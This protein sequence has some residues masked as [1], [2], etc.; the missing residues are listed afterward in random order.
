[1]KKIFLIGL[2]LLTVSSFA[3]EV[4][5]NYCECN[6]EEVVKKASAYCQYANRTH[7]CSIIAV[8]EVEDT[9]NECSK[10]S[11]ACEDVKRYEVVF[12]GK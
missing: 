5:G 7:P 8:E 4:V 2:S 9:Y 10:V 12:A 1:M 11:R 6:V 3:S